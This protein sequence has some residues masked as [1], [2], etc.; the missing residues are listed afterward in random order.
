MHESQ[1]RLNVQAIASTHV[2]E[3]VGVDAAAMEE[4]LYCLGMDSKEL[5]GL[6]KANILHILCSSEMDFQMLRRTM[7]LRNARSRSVATLIDFCAARQT[8]RDRR[9]SH[10]ARQAP[11]L[12]V[13][14]LTVPA[15]RGRGRIARYIMSFLL[16][17]TTQEPM[18]AT[19]CVCLA[20]GCHHRTV[21][22]RNFAQHTRAAHSSP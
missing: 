18:P 15:L 8:R 2:M 19:G 3:E 16:D 17:E 14:L 22:V 10:V 5:E 20:H 1:H 4:F 12:V 6:E 21:G 9:R 7:F 11:H 13:A